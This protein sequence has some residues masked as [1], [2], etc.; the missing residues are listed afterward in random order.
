[1][2]RIILLLLSPLFLVTSVLAQDA[3]ID[4]YMAYDYFK[5]DYKYLNEDFAITISHNTFQSLVEQYQFYPDK[6]EKYKDSLA[7]VMCGEFDNWQQVNIAVNRLGFTWLRAGYC[8]WL[9]ED[10]AKQKGE[11]MGFNHPYLFYRYMRDDDQ[12]S[13]V[14][15]LF[16]ADLKEKI[17]KYT[18]NPDVYSMNTREF[19]RYALVNNPQRINDFKK[20]KMDCKEEDCCQTSDSDKESCDSVGISNK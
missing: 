18:H 19:F 10:E 13:E 12:I 11:E 20:L 15:I 8:F 7:V 1:M 2:M 4:E 16:L 5:H 17:E 6:I 14:K 9:S 3:N